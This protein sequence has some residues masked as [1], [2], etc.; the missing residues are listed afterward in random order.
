M[1]KNFTIRQFKFPFLFLTVLFA[2]VFIQ[3]RK[4][5]KAVWKPDP[6]TIE[7][8]GGAFYL[9]ASDEEVDMAMINR[10]KL[11]SIPS[12]W[13]DRTEITNAQYRS[14]VNYV[15]DSLCYL[16]LY[17]GGINQTEDT[18]LKVDW[19]K[20]KR[21]NYSSKAVIEK[22]NELLLS[23]DNRIQGRI[24]IDPNKLIY[25]TV[26]IDLKAAARAS[27][28]LEQAIGKFIVAQNQ[29]V[30]PDSLVWMRDYSYSYNEPLTRLYFSHRSFNE[31]PVVGITWKQ[32]NA[33]CY[34]RTN[35]SDYF[36]G[37]PGRPDLK[38]DAIYRLPT[39]AEW[40]YAARGGLQTNAMYPWGSP[41][42]RTKQGWLL[43]NFKP[44]RGDYYGGS[45]NKDNIYT[46]KVE[47]FPL[48]GYGLADMAGNVA[49]W[50]GSVYYEGG[51]NFLGDLS[52]D[53]QYN[54]KDDDPVSMK[55]KVVRGG[56]WKDI[57]YNC[58]VSTRNYEYQDTA[59]S[60]IGFRCALSM[61]PKTK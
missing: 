21:I 20:V 11:V 29:P 31:Y 59:K 38:V 9:G 22:L 48:N 44:G 55:R 12:F 18:V 58:Q 4:P 3:A 56:S 40:E 23:P 33:F 24:E 37:R 26:Y 35:N 19:T 54:A 46:M 50:T 13:M 60:Y 36:S 52:P 28:G 15:R 14:F 49:E 30:Y 42:S 53:L 57:A 16:A 8:K 1:I 61:S 27:K 43:A 32:A 7:I 25:K 41:N 2:L 45:P 10:K 51:Y 39:E 5:K 34:W 6:N 17:G 47:S